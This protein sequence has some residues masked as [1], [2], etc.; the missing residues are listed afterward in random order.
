MRPS[1][2]GRRHRPRRRVSRLCAAAR[3]AR[4]EAQRPRLVA[5]AVL[6]RPRPRRFARHPPPQARAARVSARSV[7]LQPD[8]NAFVVSGFSRTEMRRSCPGRRHRPRRRV[9]R[10]CAA[11]RHARRE[12][13]RPRLVA[14]AVLWRPR[15][16]R[17]ARHPPPQ[18]RAAPPVVSGFSRTECVRGALVRLAGQQRA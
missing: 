13:Q 18:A 17:F 4:R 7:R 2:P 9:S 15:P 1:C 5:M 8:R 16:R 14:M 12:A 10:L 11:A 6:W 3:H